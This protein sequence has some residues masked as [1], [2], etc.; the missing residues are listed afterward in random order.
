[1]RASGNR[2]ASGPTPVSC[3]TTSAGAAMSEPEFDLEGVFD[4]DYLYFYDAFLTPERNEAETGTIVR[5][6]GLEPGMR[7]LD[8]PCG[9]G[10]IANLLAARGMEVV[11][12]DITPSFLQRARADAAATGAEVT[13]VEGDMRALPD[14]GTFD[15]AINWFTSIGYFSDDDTRRTFAGFRA[16]LR[17]AGTLLI[18]TQH[19]DGLLRR[20]LPSTM[21]ERDG[22]LMVDVSRYEPTDGFIRT[23]RIVVRDGRVRRT[24]FSVRLFAFT[25]LRDWLLAAGFTGVEG[26]DPDGNPLQMDSRRLVVR[27]RA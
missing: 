20:L 8:V 6:A 9:H 14:L 26:L 22:D 5:L 13:Y 2:A 23:E 7:V 17:D 10:R 27:A 24:N 12:V 11:G 15:V 4:P 18:E 25:E 19:R 21:Q 1:M 3:A 16:A